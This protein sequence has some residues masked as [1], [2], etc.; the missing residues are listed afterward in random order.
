MNTKMIQPKFLLGLLICALLAFTLDS[1]RLL[2]VPK[3]VFY[4]VAS[5]GQY[6][7]HNVQVGLVDGLSFLTFWKSGEARIKNLELRVAELSVAKNQAGALERENRELRK[8]LGVTSLAS[9]RQLPVVVLGLSRY[10]EIG[11]GQNQGVTVGQTVVYLDNLIGRVVSVSGRTSFVQLPS[12]PDARIAV[13]VGQARGLVSGQFGSGLEISQVAQNEDI[14]PGDLVSTSGEGG[15][16]LPGML[17]GKLGTINT[18]QTGLFKE[19]EVIPLIDYKQLTT[20]FV[21]LD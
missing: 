11:A 21:V 16:Y 4:T 8:Q 9:H 2:E 13:G 19:A 5:P 7:L 18:D 10:L 3:T 6:L 14:R 1:A 17:V 20:V 15:T 12:D